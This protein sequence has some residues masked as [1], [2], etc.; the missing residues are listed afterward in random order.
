L[1]ELPNINEN[2]NVAK[3]QSEVHVLFKEII[4]LQT[5]QILDE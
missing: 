4:S 5:G 1:K 2:L 3:Y